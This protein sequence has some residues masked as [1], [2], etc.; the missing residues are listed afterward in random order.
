[1]SRDS[2]HEDR[3]SPWYKEKSVYQDIYFDRSNGVHRFLPSHLL[4]EE[5]WRIRGG[6]KVASC[7][8]STSGYM[9]STNFHKDL[10]QTLRHAR[11]QQN[12]NRAKDS[13]YEDRPHENV[14]H[15]T[16]GH[17]VLESLVD[18]ILTPL[19]RRRQGRA[20]PYQNLHRFFAPGEIAL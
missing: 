11:K 20:P 9:P 10:P 2:R 16:N 1:M 8:L 12:Y 17:G 7:R 18:T 4:P 6:G 19:V 15:T 3:L 5:P 13:K 14:V